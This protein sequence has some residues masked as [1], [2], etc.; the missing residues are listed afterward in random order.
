MATR[1]LDVLLRGRQCRRLLCIGAALLATALPAPARP[2]EASS[3]PAETRALDATRSSA[4]F[5]VKVLWLVGVHGRFGK[6]HG[7]VTLD[8]EHKTVIADARI[9]VDVITMRNHSYEDW[10]KSD[11]F[12]DV[13]AYPQIRFVSDP[14][15]LDDLRGGGTIAGT[16]SL[17][18]IDKR[19]TFAVTPSAC[20]QAIANACPVLANGSIRRS[21]FGMKSRRG[22][23][24][25]KVELG[26]SIY[27]VTA[28]EQG[29]AQ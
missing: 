10:V 13:R 12:F 18:G 3:P 4:D 2:D 11:E 1:G 19:V 27:L 26:F 5:E 14:F 6:V 7:T 24:S 17:R 15:P 21:D 22:T 25:D 20:P 29:R 23:L 9:D 28:A 8:R 16:L